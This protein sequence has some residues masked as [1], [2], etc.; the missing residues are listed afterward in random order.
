MP[1]IRNNK[2]SAFLFISFL[3][4]H[5][6]KFL[7]LL[8]TD[9][10]PF[11]LQI[12]LFFRLFYL[13]IIPQ[14]ELIAMP[15]CVNCGNDLSSHP[16]AVFCPNC[17]ARTRLDTPS[18][19][20]TAPV[21]PAPVAV[22]LTASNM[23]LPTPG[24][25]IL[26]LNNTAPVAPA[27]VAVAPTVNNTLPVATVT[28]ITSSN[29]A[30]P[31]AEPLDRPSHSSSIHDTVLGELAPQLGLVKK[32]SK[33]KLT[34][35]NASQLKNGRQEAV[36]MTFSG[37]HEGQHLGRQFAEEKRHGPWRY[38]ASAL[39]SDG[40]PLRVKYENSK[41]LVLADA[42]LLLAV[43]WDNVREGVGVSFVGGTGGY[44]T[45]D[46][47]S[48]GRKWIVYSD[49]SIG[50]QADSDLR[51]GARVE[52]DAREL[53]GCFGCFCIPFGCSLYRN[54]T[55]DSDSYCELGLFFLCFLAPLPGCKTRQ[56]AKPNTNDFVNSSDP[57]DQAGWLTRDTQDFGSM[58]LC[59]TGGRICD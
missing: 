27:P 14:P 37:A 16:G 9:Y 39:G 28:G 57:R 34:F 45:K 36:E 52:I 51:L 59:A 1:E 29:S 40:S 5:L 47:T 49:G 50:P 53:R 33:H 3:V 25:T 19:N 10:H 41:W 12:S 56:R 20:N 22:A 30:L 58:H 4:L 26:S 43:D 7:A 11:R 17:G 46:P 13:I 35:S 48:K 23:S 55:D 2:F 8:S 42:E 38:T 15:F 54:C 18:L 24:L 6:V 44:S 21:A 31:M 32:T